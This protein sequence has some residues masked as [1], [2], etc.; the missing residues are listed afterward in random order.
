MSDPSGCSVT[1]TI[2]PAGIPGPSSGL[3]G[4]S[5]TR[6]LACIEISVSV[7]GSAAR[8]KECHQGHEEHPCRNPFGRLVPCQK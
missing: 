4:R 5:E 2:T 8:S 1:K 6:V 7:S 3:S